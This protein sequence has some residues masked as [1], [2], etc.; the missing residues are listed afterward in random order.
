MEAS[1]AGK[2][3]KEIVQAHLVAPLVLVLVGLGYLMAN[4]NIIPITPW[5]AVA[6]YWPLVVVYYGVNGILSLTKRK[7]H[8]GHLPMPDILVSVVITAFGLY[9]LAPRVGWELRFLSWGVVWPSLLIAL[10]LLLAANSPLTSGSSSQDGSQTTLVGE[11]Y[12]GGQS[13]FVDDLYIRH[14]IG[15]VDLDLT[16]AIIP[17][18]DVKIDI[19][20]GIGEVSILLP[21]DLPYAIDCSCSIGDIN[22]AEHEESGLGKRFSY[23]T[24]D[25]DEATRR[26]TLRIHWKIG[27]VK[28]RCLG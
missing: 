25:Y 21:A 5:Q 18:R 7:S 8:S 1:A 3:R 11:V 4:L 6:Q 24:D 16:Q 14:A 26:L 15:E 13:W 27:E 17:D 2:R 12:R 19:A 20:G 22:V 9:L 23:R 28:L 10:G